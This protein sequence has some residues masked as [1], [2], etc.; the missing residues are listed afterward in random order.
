MN[1]LCSMINCC[2]RVVIIELCRNDIYVCTPQLSFVLLLFLVYCYLAKKIK[3]YIIQFII[4]PRSL[5]T[6]SS[7]LL[8]YGCRIVVK[9]CSIYMY[10]MRRAYVIFERYTYC[11]YG[12][13][14]RVYASSYRPGV[15]KKMKRIYYRCDQ[16]N[17]RR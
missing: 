16:Y 2:S 17:I 11:M 5:S 12:H 6:P 1:N 14:V 13:K 10:G 4:Q 9:R 7:S 3:M 8:E 15:Q